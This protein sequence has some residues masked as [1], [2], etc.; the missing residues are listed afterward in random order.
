MQNK[1][2][3]QRNKTCS[4][5]QP[6]TISDESQI[7]SLPPAP[8]EQKAN[9]STNN[10]VSDISMLQLFYIEAQNPWTIIDRKAL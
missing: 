7:Q 6:Y 10:S 3:L 9:S 8:S 4:N 2:A 1:A 5:I